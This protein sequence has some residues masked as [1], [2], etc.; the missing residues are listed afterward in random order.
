MALFS[1]IR[2]S[3]E[4]ISKSLMCMHVLGECY[5]VQKKELKYVHVLKTLLLRNGKRTTQQEFEQNFVQEGL[6]EM[7]E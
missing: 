5:D 6:I 7:W 2:R 1:Q 4:A 3:I